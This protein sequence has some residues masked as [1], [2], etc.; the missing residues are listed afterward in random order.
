MNEEQTELHLIVC[1]NF[2]GVSL[3]KAERY[4]KR[5]MG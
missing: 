1:K 2:E 4:I 5:N 3:R